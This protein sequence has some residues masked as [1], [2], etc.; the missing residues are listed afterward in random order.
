MLSS[1]VRKVSGKIGG[2][3]ANDDLGVRSG[4]VR[5]EVPGRNHRTRPK[6]PVFPEEEDWRVDPVTR[7]SSTEGGRGYKR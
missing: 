4:G 1:P 6:V 5:E 7:D 3:E 2:G